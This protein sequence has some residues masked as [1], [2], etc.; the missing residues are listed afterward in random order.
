MATSTS[1]AIF[2]GSDQR[3]R[4]ARMRAGLNEIIKSVPC[5]F[6]VVALSSCASMSDVSPILRQ[7]A[8]C[9]STTLRSV[10]GI[11][12]VRMRVATSREGT[13]PTIS[14]Q[15][16]DSAGRRRDARFIFYMSKDDAGRDLYPF[17]ATGAAGFR[18]TNEG[19]PAQS[20]LTELETQCGAT[21]I[22]I[23]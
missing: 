1:A 17:D 23:T 16:V 11:E 22:I 3:F 9:V 15:F 13:H 8:E 4:F 20:R 21:G 18:V 12:N 14:Y 10:P 19:S 2:Y 7:V 6:A 5:G